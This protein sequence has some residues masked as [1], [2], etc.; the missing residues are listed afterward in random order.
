MSVIA[1]YSITLTKLL[2]SSDRTI[3]TT[4]KPIDDDENRRYQVCGYGG[5]S[6]TSGSFGIRISNYAS[7]QGGGTSNT[8]EYAVGIM[9]YHNDIY[10]PN[11]KIYRNVETTIAVSYK[12]SNNTC[13]L[14]V[15]NP[16]SGIWEMDSQVL[17]NGQ[18]NTELGEGFMIGGYPVDY[19]GDN[20]YLSLIHI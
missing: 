3:I 6:N 5:F 1:L 13:Y 8:S 20:I 18:Y 10:F 9:G 16:S 7:D 15:K 12:S 17:P 4:I 11:L 19:N 2:G 14:F